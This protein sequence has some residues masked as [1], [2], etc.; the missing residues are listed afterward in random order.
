MFTEP[1][2]T[3]IITESKDELQAVKSGRHARQ[4]W[5]VAALTGDRWFMAEEVGQPGQAARRFVSTQLRDLEPILKEKPSR[6]RCFAYLASSELRAPLFEEVVAVTDLSNMGGLVYRL[7]AGLIGVESYG[8]PRRNFVG[9]ADESP[10]P[11]IHGERV[12]EWR[13]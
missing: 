4:S 10:S 12:F 6:W 9:P 7:K 3:G 8:A 1:T 5:R 13:P 2:L 11:L